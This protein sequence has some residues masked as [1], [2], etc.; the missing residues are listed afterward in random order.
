MIH[1]IA[2]WAGLDNGSGGQYLFWSG[3][4]GDVTIFAAAVAFYWHH[5]C[6]VSRCWRPGLH[7]VD[8]TPFTCCR[9]HHPSVDHTARTTGQTIADAHDLAKRK[10]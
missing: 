3:I 6:H 9:V 1:L 4:F 7:K 8:G 2:H 5:T 10:T